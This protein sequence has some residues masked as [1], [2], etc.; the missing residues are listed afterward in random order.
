MAKFVLFRPF[1][2][3]FPI[4]VILSRKNGGRGLSNWHES[5][6]FP[7]PDGTFQFSPIFKSIQLISFQ[8][9][10][11][12]ILNYLHKLFSKQINYF[13]YLNIF[14]FIYLVFFFFISKILKLLVLSNIELIPW[15]FDRLVIALRSNQLVPTKKP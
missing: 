15:S 6:I 12:I 9:I 13:Y 11:W 7:T 2:A 10:I 1:W 4:F 3:F 5:F 8:W 14:V